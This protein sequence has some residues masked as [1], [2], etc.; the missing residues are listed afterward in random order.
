MSFLFFI[1]YLEHVDWYAPMH[2][3]CQTR[4]CTRRSRCRDFEYFILLIGCVLVMA[5]Y[6]LRD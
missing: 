6:D 1:F 5:D 2:I 4:V 3:G